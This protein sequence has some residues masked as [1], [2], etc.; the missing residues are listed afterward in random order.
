MWFV[1]QVAKGTLRWERENK[2]EDDS[3]FGTY[4]AKIKS[5]S[6]C[7]PHTDTQAD[8]VDQFWQ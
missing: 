7:I 6:T 5:L 8:L 3:M 4:W 2:I 1:E